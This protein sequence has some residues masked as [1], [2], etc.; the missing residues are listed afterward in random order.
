MQPQQLLDIVLQAK[1]RMDEELRAE[2]WH[3]GDVMPDVYQEDG[4]IKIV[5]YGG[6]LLPEKLTMQKFDE[7]WLVTPERIPF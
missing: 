3:L 2:E 6:D 1:E 4:K 7:H 5:T